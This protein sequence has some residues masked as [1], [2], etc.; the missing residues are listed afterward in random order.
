[1]TEAM[2]CY[3]NPSSLHSV[4]YDASRML[5]DARKNI[6]A[7]LGLR[8]GSG[9]SLIFTGSG[10]EANNLAIFGSVYAKARRLSNRIITTNSEHPSVGEPLAQLEKSGFEIVRLATRRG[11]IDMEELRKALAGGAFMV[12]VMMVNNETGAVYDIP[13]IF[14]LAKRL[15]PDAVTHCDATQGY[16]KLPFSPQKLNADMVTVSAHKIHGPKGIGALCVAPEIMKAKKLVPIIRGGGQE[17]GFRSGTENMIGIAGFAGAAAEYYP[18]LAENSA[19]IT[20]LRVYTEKLIGSI[21]ELRINKPEGERAPHIINL[22]LPGIKSETMVH[23]LSSKG[24]AVSSGSACS[25]H[26]EHIS[27]SLIGF[28]L[29][30]REAACSIR[31]SFCDTNTEAEADALCGALREGLASLVRTE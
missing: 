10:T 5:E 21:E 14:S 26:N 20:A 24:I 6:L 18:H 7:S 27:Q 1:M 11:V 3:G 13:G 19:K 15:C 23:F 31:I 2:D 16:M 8:A 4:G 12:T 17:S 30:A 25:S 28:G 9:Y 22:T 29:D